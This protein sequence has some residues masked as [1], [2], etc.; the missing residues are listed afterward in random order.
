[1]VILF[2]FWIILSFFSSTFSSSL[3][4]DTTV[5]NEDEAAVDDSGGDEAMFPA[6]NPDEAEQAGLLGSSSLLLSSETYSRFLTW[7]LPRPMRT[8]LPLPMED[9]TVLMASAANWVKVAS[10]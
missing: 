9:D 4:F 6:E 7:P 2:I 5:L 10:G 3:K 1:M 8:L